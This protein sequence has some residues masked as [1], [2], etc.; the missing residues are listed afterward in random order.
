MPDHLIFPIISESLFPELTARSRSAA[1][2]LATGDRQVQRSEST[3]SE[4]PSPVLAT[5]R[6]GCKD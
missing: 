3:G 5:P 6:S 1:H 4:P 2:E